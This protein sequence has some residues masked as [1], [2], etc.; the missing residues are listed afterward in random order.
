M[1]ATD[2]ACAGVQCA[3][4]VLGHQLC[5]TLT[6]AASSISIGTLA[7]EVVAGVRV[8]VGGG[9]WYGVNFFAVGDGVGAQGTAAAAICALNRGK[10]SSTNGT[11]ECK[12][13]ACTIERAEHVEGTPLG[14]TLVTSKHSLRT[15]LHCLL[16]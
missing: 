12:H 5:K 9:P 2:A 14:S 15:S 16:G 13:A 4:L 8:G 7:A 10:Q 6:H 1:S 11:K 3:Q